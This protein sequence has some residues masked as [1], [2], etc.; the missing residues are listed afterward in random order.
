[1]VAELHVH[2]LRRR[3][4]AVPTSSPRPQVSRLLPRSMGRPRLLV[5]GSGG[6]DGDEGQRPRCHRDL[7]KVVLAMEVRS[8]QAGQ[9]S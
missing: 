6:S 8:W 5:V 2:W 4:G 9:T 7:S 1:M 3:A